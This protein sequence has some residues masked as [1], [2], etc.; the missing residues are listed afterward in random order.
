MFKTVIKLIHLKDN[1]ITPVFQNSRVLRYLKS[2]CKY[3]NVKSAS[4][5]F[6]RRETLKNNF[7]ND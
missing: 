1:K 2:D 3:T 7:S 4:D 6:Y 5:Q